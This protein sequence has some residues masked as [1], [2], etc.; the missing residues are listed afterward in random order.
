MSHSVLRG[1]PFQ[2]IRLLAAADVGRAGNIPVWVAVGG[3]VVPDGEDIRLRA[4]V[5]IAKLDDPDGVDFHYGFDVAA[6]A[7]GE[8]DGTTW[9]KTSITGVM[10]RGHPPSIGHMLVGASR[11][12]DPPA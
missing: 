12:A 9:S 11:R 6:A 1:S 8:G 3:R 5:R 2:T 4:K 10:N 7:A